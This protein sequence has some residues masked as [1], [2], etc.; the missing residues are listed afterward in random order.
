ME[1]L[2]RPVPLFLKNIDGRWSASLSGDIKDPHIERIAVS[3]LNKSALVLT[4][5]TN[6][7]S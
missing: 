1:S 3:P 5:A 6:G 2:T 4:D 7:G